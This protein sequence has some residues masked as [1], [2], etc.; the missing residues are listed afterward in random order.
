[1]P[2]TT[3]AAPITMPGL[4]SYVPGQ[5]YDRAIHGKPLSLRYDDYSL[6]V[7]KYNQFVRFCASE[8][9]LPN[10]SMLTD[11]AWSLAGQIYSAQPAYTELFADA[12]PARLACDA[13][14]SDM[15]VRLARL[16]E[17]VPV[18]MAAE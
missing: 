11:E 8:L 14:K 7:T 4:I 2:I 13:L 16:L 15:R 10:G 17:P 5:L 3:Q 6:E 18:Q 12:A 1:M 9:G